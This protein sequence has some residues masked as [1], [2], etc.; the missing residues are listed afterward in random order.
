MSAPAPAPLNG[1]RPGRALPAW[2]GV[3]LALIVQLGSA[4][5]FYGRLVERVEQLQ[6]QVDRLT[7]IVE[8]RP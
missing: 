8:S 5:Y 2:A 1:Y 7:A 4:L 6:R 3:L